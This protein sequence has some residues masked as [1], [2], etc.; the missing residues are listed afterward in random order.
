MVLTACKKAE[1]LDMTV[2]SKS[3]LEGADFTEISVTDAWNVS[4]VQDDQV[5]GVELEYSAF[6]EEYLDVKQTGNL[7][8]IGFNTEL[9][10]PSGTVMKA[11]V[12][13]RTLEA[14][15]LDKAS[16]CRGDT[17]TGNTRIILES[18]SQLVDF[19]LNGSYH[20]ITINEASTFKGD[21][22]ADSVLLVMT[23]DARMSTFG[24]QIQRLRLSMGDSYRLNMANTP[25]DEAF[26]SFEN[27]EATLFV[28]TLLRGSLK[29]ASTLYLFG[30]PVIEINCDDTST[31]QQLIN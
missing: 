23:N 2:V 27:S 19:N 30:D 25:V 28:N 31:I 26:V 4:I 8:S 22:T 29:D 12:H 3:V 20:E 7:L 9:N 17:L 24:G 5:S 14:I 21:L 10:L 1:K 13:L 15:T 6:L 16:I 18:D 11:E